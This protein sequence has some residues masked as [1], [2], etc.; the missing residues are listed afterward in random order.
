MLRICL[1]KIFLTVRKPSFHLFWPKPFVEFDQ[2]LESHQPTWNGIYYYFF[3]FDLPKQIC[4]LLLRRHS[5]EGSWWIFL[6]SFLFFFRE[7]EL[8][9]DANFCLLQ[10]WADWASKV[11]DFLPP[12]LDRNSRAF[13]W[14]T[15]PRGEATISTSGHAGSEG[16]A[17]SAWALNR[18]CQT[19]CQ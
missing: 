13:V 2:H 15:L 9:Q 3:L 4:H 16:W 14:P 5:I 12:P 1:N 19:H 11:G 10:S 6:P 7:Y 17:G 8:L 18:D